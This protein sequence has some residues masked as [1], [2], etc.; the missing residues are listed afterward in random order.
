MASVL[1][2]PASSTGSP[3]TFMMRPSVSGP[4]GTEIGPPVSVT[5]WPRTS[6]SVPSIA[7]VRT[8]FSPRCWATSRTRRLPWFVVSSAFRI[9]GRKSGNVTST[10]A[11]MTWLTVPTAPL[12]LLGADFAALVDALAGAAFLAAGLLAAVDSFGVAALAMN[13]PLSLDSRAPRRPK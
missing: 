1:S 9:S 3:M 5:S 11:P 13:Y 2:G 12:R 10:T 6:P 4:T 7:M 8:V